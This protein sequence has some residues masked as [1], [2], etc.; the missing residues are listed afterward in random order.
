MEFD[1]DN[2]WY[3]IDCEEATQHQIL[4]TSL[5]IGKL[6]AIFITHLY[7]DHYYGL[8]GVLYLKTLDTALSSLIV[9]GPKGIKQFIECAMDVSQERLGYKLEIIE[10]EANKRLTFDKF[11]LQVLPLRDCVESF[12]YYI[13]EHDITNRNICLVQ[14]LEEG[15]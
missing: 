9:Y 10:I 2:K 12:A 13:Q 3:F 7:G 8:L 14:Y 6:C 5:S 15:L 1:Q 11:S 4:K